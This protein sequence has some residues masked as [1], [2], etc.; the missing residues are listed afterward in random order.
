MRCSSV[1]GREDGGPLVSISTEM[2]RCQSFRRHNSHFRLSVLFVEIEA[3]KLVVIGAFKLVEIGAF[4]LVV[5]GA[6]KLL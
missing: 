2:Q 3:F 5:S 4:K 1:C 6:F